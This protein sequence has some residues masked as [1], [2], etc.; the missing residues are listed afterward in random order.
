[1]ACITIFFL[2]KMLVILCL[3]KSQWDCNSDL[4]GKVFLN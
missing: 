4:K 3:C 1:M 2:S